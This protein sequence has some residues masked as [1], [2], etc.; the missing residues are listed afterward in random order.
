MKTIKPE[1]CQECRP[2]VLS[3]PTPGCCTY[4]A[5]S[6]TMFDMVSQWTMQTLTKMDVIQIDVAQKHKEATARSEDHESW[7]HGT[8]CWKPPNSSCHPAV[9]PSTCH[10]THAH[11]EAISTCAEWMCQNQAP[12]ISPVRVA[13]HAIKP[14]TKHHTWKSV[15]SSSAPNKPYVAHRACS[16]GPGRGH[17]A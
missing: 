17:M 11:A 10:K 1:T 2:V 9:H 4:G 12:K 8:P 7:L 16:R 5:Q 3:G 13:D 6:H 14:S 15:V